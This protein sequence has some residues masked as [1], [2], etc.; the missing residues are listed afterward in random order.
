M[1]TC[2]DALER[3]ECDATLCLV[4]QLFLLQEIHVGN[5]EALRARIVSFVREPFALF[6]VAV[7]C[8]IGI[9]TRLVL[10]TRTRTSA[11]STKTHAN[12]RESI[13][14]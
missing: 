13:H 1:P 6:D 8:L 5:A 12:T 2:F 7:A 9:L 11:P 4:A 14:I 10:G 3:T